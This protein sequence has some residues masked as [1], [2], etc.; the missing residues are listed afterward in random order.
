MLPTHPP[1]TKL[2]VVQG[3]QLLNIGNVN[4]QVT[5]SHQSGRHPLQLTTTKRKHPRRTPTPPIPPIPPKPTHTQ[6]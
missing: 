5:K 3:A 6:H 4:T 1:L 2:R